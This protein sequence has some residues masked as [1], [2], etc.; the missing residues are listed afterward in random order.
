MHGGWNEIILKYLPTEKHIEC[1]KNNG[2]PG[3]TAKFPYDLVY[4]SVLCNF[5]IEADH[6]FLIE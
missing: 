5:V 4:R 1:Y 2:I 6:H 3:K